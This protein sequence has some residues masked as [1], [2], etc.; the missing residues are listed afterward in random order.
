MVLVLVLEVR[1]LSL[2]LVLAVVVLVR[3]LV[4]GTIGW[5]HRKVTNRWRLVNW[6]ALVTLAVRVEQQVVVVCRQSG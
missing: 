5:C 1:L 6:R 3:I 4:G 2:L